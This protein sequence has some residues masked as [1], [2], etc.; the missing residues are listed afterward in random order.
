MNHTCTLQPQPQSVAALWLALISRPAAGRRLS[1]LGWLGEILR[2]FVRPKTVTHPGISRGGQELNP[3]PMSGETNVITTRQ[4]GHVMLI[5]KALSKRY[6]LTTR[7]AILL[8][9]RARSCTNGM[10]R[11]PAFTHSYKASSH[12]DRYSLFL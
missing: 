9:T 1:W 4:P 5:C 11:I 2:W 12:F 3:R 6:A 10:S 7:H 8:A